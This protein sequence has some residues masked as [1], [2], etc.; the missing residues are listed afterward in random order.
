MSPSQ[1]SR[2]VDSHALDH[3]KAKIAK[4]ERLEEGIRPY[5]EYQ[6][7]LEALQARIP[8]AEREQAN[9]RAANRIIRD[10]KLG[11]EEKIAR[12][13]AECRVHP[14]D[15]PGLL[16]PDSS[17]HVGFRLLGNAASI[18][19]M[20]QRRQTL[21][22]EQNRPSVTFTFPGG[23]VED[24]AE[25]GLVRVFLFPARQPQTVVKLLA[26]RF[27]FDPGRQCY[28]R[29]RDDAARAVI[30]QA[31]GVAWPAAPAVAP[32]PAAGFAAIRP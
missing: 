20:K 26:R 4:A 19:R 21:D 7:G 13:A 32:R 14:A 8:Q 29:P 2:S 28:C 30:V 24:C 15:A 6:L 11:H 17:G 10:P 31:T 9:L 23:R 12:L 27:V 25:D 16:R 1:T 5:P 3:L 22:S 18:R